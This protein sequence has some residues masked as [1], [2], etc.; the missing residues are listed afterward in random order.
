MWNDST[1]H[2]SRVRGWDDVPG[3]PSGACGGGVGTGG[4][5][6]VDAE[7]RRDDRPHHPGHRADDGHDLVGVAELP[8]RAGEDAG[9]HHE[10]DDDDDSPRQ[11]PPFVSRA[12]HPDTSK[13]PADE[14]AEV[15]AFWVARVG[16]SSWGRR[17]E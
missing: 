4:G 3:C 8:D 14:C 12:R 9:D 17:D 5:G 10:A 1:T 7:E 13:A 2:S 16:E 6:G 15:T 11:A